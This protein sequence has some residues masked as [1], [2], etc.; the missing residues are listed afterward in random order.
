MCVCWE[1]CHVGCM[2]VCVVRMCVVFVCGGPR[3]MGVVVMW[4]CGFDVCVC[5]EGSACTQHQVCVCVHV[6]LTLRPHPG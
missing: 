3:V 2:C 1:E 4:L 6:K 5:V